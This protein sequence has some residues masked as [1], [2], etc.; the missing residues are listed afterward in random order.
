MNEIRTVELTPEERTLFDEAR[1]EFA[2]DDRYSAKSFEGMALLAE[3]LLGRKAVPGVRLRYFTDP[4]MNAAGRGR[5]RRDVFEGNGTSG[6]DILRH[7]HFWKYLLYFVQ[8]PDLPAASR[9]GFLRILEEDRGTSGMLLGQVTK[10]V[11][12]EVRRQGLD[13]G[14]A[15]EEFFKLAHEAGRPDLALPARNAAKAVRR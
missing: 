3:S 1:R 9:E 7:P 6:R 8:G 13:G 12:G 4:E 14:D 5:S 2:R 11:R 15:G 10:F